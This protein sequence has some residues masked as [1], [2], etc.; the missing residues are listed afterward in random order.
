MKKKEG[1]RKLVEIFDS[2]EAEHVR[3]SVEEQPPELESPP[4][5]RREDVSLDP[6]QHYLREIGRVRL[7][8]PKE[9]IDLARRIEKGDA[10]ARERMIQA[11]LRLVVYIAKHYVS[12]SYGLSL[13]DLIQEG[14]MGLFKAVE[15]YN[16]RRG[17]RFPTYARWWIRQAITQAIRHQAPE[18]RPVIS[19]YTQARERLRRELGRDPEPDEVAESLDVDI[20]DVQLMVELLEESEESPVQEEPYEDGGFMPLLPMDRKALTGHLT[21]ILHELSPREQEILSLRF[22]LA[23][24]EPRTLEE[25]GKKFGLTRERVRQIENRALE[26][27]RKLEKA[28]ILEEF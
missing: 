19:K 6:V 28:K 12:R 21:E 26:K 15:R 14:N 20:D 24:D 18:V 5:P 7:L 17:V 23:D 8:T 2:L 1:R 13:L 10:A 16:W 4:M 22:G 3:V 9:E 11:N 27:I 25:I